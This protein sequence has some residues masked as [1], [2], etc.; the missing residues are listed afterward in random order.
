M[1]TR[2]IH[3]KIWEDNYFAELS[4]EEKLAFLYLITN[5]RVNIC[6]AYE[7]PDRVACFDLNIDNSSWQRIKEKFIKDKRFMFY[8]VWVLVVNVEKYNNYRFSERNEKAYNKELQL[9]PSDIRIKF[10]LE[11]TQDEFKELLN[12]KHKR[13]VS[14]YQHRERVEKALGRKLKENEVVHHID[15]NKGNNDLSN[16]VVMDSKEHQMYHNGKIAFNDTNMI[17]VSST[18]DTSYKSEIINNKSKIRNQKPSDEFLANIRKE[19]KDK[20]K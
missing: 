7:L 5:S 19:I 15:N 17:L 6:G 8:G 2:I 18:N 1:K 10:A 20:L 4:V 13:G 14:G 11:F 3:T 16:L 12:K 9:L